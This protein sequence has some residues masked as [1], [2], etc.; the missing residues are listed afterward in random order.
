M[1]FFPRE[2]W[3]VFLWP[4]FCPLPLF[5]NMVFT[6][7]AAIRQAF[8]LL[9]TSSVLR[10]GERRRGGIDRRAKSLPSLLSRQRCVYVSRCAEVCVTVWRIKWK[11]LRVFMWT[12]KC[13]DAWMFLGNFS[14]QCCV[15]RHVFFYNYK[16]NRMQ[17]KVLFGLFMSLC[18][19]ERGFTYAYIFLL[20]CN[21]KC[22][23]ILASVKS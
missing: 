9:L 11:V 13:L 23:L 21:R 14:F 22:I 8:A 1:A 17:T 7:R 20:F 2:V 4:H 16:K 6:A 3:R 12:V 18:S 10:E 5:L 15:S 19:V